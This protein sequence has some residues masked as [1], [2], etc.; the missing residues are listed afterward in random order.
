MLFWDVEVMAYTPGQCLD[1]VLG[2]GDF[3]RGG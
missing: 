2:L 3:R 1:P